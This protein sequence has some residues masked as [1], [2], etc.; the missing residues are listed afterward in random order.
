MLALPIVVIW[1]FYG[2][3]RSLIHAAENRPY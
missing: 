2:M 1:F 3:V